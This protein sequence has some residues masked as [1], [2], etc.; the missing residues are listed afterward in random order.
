[1]GNVFPLQFFFFW[2]GVGGGGVC[3]F[4]FVS[5]FY[6]FAILGNDLKGLWVYSL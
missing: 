3:L 6:V 1:M 4:L 2:G 5:D